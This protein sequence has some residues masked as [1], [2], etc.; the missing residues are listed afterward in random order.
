MRPTL[1]TYWTA[2]SGIETHGHGLSPADADAMWALHRDEC[3]AALNS[4][5]LNAAMEAFTKVFELETA[6]IEAKRFVRAGEGFDS[7]PRVARCG[8]DNGAIVDI[9]TNERTA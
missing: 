4:N 3:A 9:E 1:K 6:S 2:G 5:N 7:A 8:A